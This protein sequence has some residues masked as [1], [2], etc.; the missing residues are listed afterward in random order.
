MTTKVIV[1]IPHI[2]PGD[3]VV[4]ETL[5]DTNDVDITKLVKEDIVRLVGV[6]EYNIWDTQHINIYERRKTE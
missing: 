2:H 4:I 5:Q 1:S 3:E 6:K